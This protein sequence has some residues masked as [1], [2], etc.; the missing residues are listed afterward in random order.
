MILLIFIV[1]VL[2]FMQHLH[3]AERTNPL[4]SFK[5]Y[6][7]NIIKH[8]NKINQNFIIGEDTEID[9]IPFISS[10]DDILLDKFN[11][12]SIDC[13]ANIIDRSIGTNVKHINN[14][15]INDL[16]KS[17][18]LK[19]TNK[20]HVII[21]LCEFIKIT[22][23]E[24]GNLEPYSNNFNEFSLYGK[25]SIDEE[26][27]IKIGS[28]KYDKFN[29]LQFFCVPVSNRIWL[30]YL[31]LEIS[32]IYNDDY[33]Y[34]PITI[35]K[36]F[37]KDIFNDIENVIDETDIKETLHNEVINENL[38]DI[39]FC[40]INNPF[41]KYDEQLNSLN[42]S[43]IIVKDKNANKDNVLETILKKIHFL[44]SY[45]KLQSNF[46]DLSFNET[47]NLINETYFTDFKKNIKKLNKNNVNINKKVEFLEKKVFGLWVVLL[48][49]MVIII[50][51]VLNNM[52]SK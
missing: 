27:W 40:K 50:L 11:F 5:Q 30:K 32:S 46:I 26:E 52:E 18:L 45:V 2:F 31:K 3:A 19:F 36:V 38:N 20:A 10:N 29:K 44:N 22:S 7:D 35:M 16:D 15:L 8:S 23:F 13:M 33:Y 1:K 47:I 49:M 34:T 12:A 25:K 37:G 6:Q 42:Q 17:L 51:N 4:V 43:S 24:I 9:L 14:L 21:E 41:V 48:G 39:D 28:F